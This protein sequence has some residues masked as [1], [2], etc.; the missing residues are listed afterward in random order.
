MVGVL[1]WLLLFIFLS[2]YVFATRGEVSPVLEKTHPEAVRGITL[3]WAENDVYHTMA[4]NWWTKSSSKSWV[5]YDIVPHRG[6]SNDYPHRVEGVVQKISTPRST[7]KNCYHNVRLTGLKPGTT[8]YFICGGLGGWSEEYSFRTIGLDQH[9]KFV[10]GGDSR[11]PHAT[12]I[13]GPTFPGARIEVSK[14]AALEKPDFVVFG[15]DLVMNGYKE[16]QWE[17]WFDDVVDKLVFADK[18]GYKRLIPLVPSVGNHDLAYLHQIGIYGDMSD[19]DYF[20]GMFALPGN[21]LWYTLDFPN[22]RLITLC[23]AYGVG[24][25][26]KGM[27]SEQ[28]TERE[29]AAQVDWL[30]EQLKSAKQKWVITTHHV[31]PIG[32][33]GFRPGMIKHW[34][35]LF[36]EYR[37]PLN[38]TGHA[39]HYTRTWPINH[40][41]LPPNF[42]DFDLTIGP[43]ALWP[44]GPPIVK[45]ANNSKD[46]VTYLVQGNWGAPMEFM[47]KDSYKLI[48]DCF[49]KAFARPSYNMI[50]DTDK[51]L[52]IVCKEAGKERNKTFGLSTVLDEFWLPYTTTEFPTA[53]YNITF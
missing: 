30:R 19:Y 29:C 52:H 8:Y 14:G 45:L 40:L 6:V 44:K 37:M 24:F 2:V 53:K 10:F 4:I 13:Y 46:G 26:E 25:A 48:Y 28:R 22:I 9:V 7:F 43:S 36:E 50:E 34:I 27:D 32:R 39:H 49:A 17:A 41:E 20:R 5:L 31:N 35:P 23:A 38:I 3:T 12:E 47:E 15:G 42:V 11:E 51:G 18:N 21:E 1:V 33:S 16:E